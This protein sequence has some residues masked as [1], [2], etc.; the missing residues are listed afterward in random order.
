MNVT[1]YKRLGTS[2][3]LSYAQVDSNW[4][5][6]EAAFAAIVNSGG[7]VTSVSASIFTGLSVAVTNPTTTPSIAITTTL[8]GFLKGN[9]TGFT[10]Q[11]K[12]VLTT[13]VS[14]VLPIANGGTNA[15]SITSNRA[16]I[17]NGTSITAS[18]V[19]STELG[20]LSGATSNIQ[21]QLNGKEPTI[22]FLPYSKG[23]LNGSFGSR[24]AALDSLT[25]VSATTAGYVLTKDGSGNATFRVLPTGAVSS[26]NGATGVVVLTVTNG[27]GTLA[28]TSTNLNIPSATTGTTGL[29]TSTDWNTFNNKINSTGGT[30]TGPILYSGVPVV[31]DELVN[32]TYVDTHGG[33]TGSVTSVALTTGTA[34]TDINVTGSPITTSGTFTLNVPSANASNRGLLTSS[35]WTIFNNK[36]SSQWITS[37]SNIYY[38]TGNVGI[39]TSSPAY[40]LHINGGDFALSNNNLLSFISVNTGSNSTYFILDNTDLFSFYLETD[41]GIPESIWQVQGALSTGTTTFVHNSAVNIVGLAGG[42]TRMVTVNNAGLIGATTIPTASQWITTGSDIYYNTG[43]VGIGATSVESGYKLDVTGAVKIRSTHS[44]FVYSNNNV[45]FTS[46]GTI[47]ALLR[48][49]IQNSDTDQYA[50]FRILNSG[51]SGLVFDSYSPSYIQAGTYDIA[52]TSLIT[53]GLNTTWNLGTNYLRIYANSI[54]FTLTSGG[55]MV[56][57]DTTSALIGSG[58]LNYRNTNGILTNTVYNASSGSSAQATMGIISNF[59]SVVM[60][61]NNNGGSPYANMLSSLNFGF[62]LNT[63]LSN[64]DFNGSF[65]R[66]YSSSSAGTLTLGDVYEYTFTGT[67]ATWSLPLLSTAFSREYALTNLGSGSITVNVTGGGTT[68]YTTSAVTSFTIAAGDRYTIHNNGTYWVVKGNNLTTGT[69]SLTNTHIFVGNSSNVAT[70]V[71]MS[72]EATIANTGA[73]TLSN[74]A[75]IGKVLTGLSITGTAIVATDN[76]LQAF[77]KTQN[78]L[79]GIV[80]SQWVTSGANIYNGNAGG[81]SIGSTS[82]TATYK[83]DV[84]GNVLVQGGWFRSV[85]NGVAFEAFLQTS[86][87]PVYYV[88]DSTTEALGKRYRFGY[89]GSSTDV[90]SFNIVNATDNIT[91]I[92]ISGAASTLGFVGINTITPSSLFNVVKTGLGVTQTNTS[93]TALENTTS[94]TNV[95]NQISPSMRW[96]GNVWQSTA[97]ASQTVDNRVFL[98]PIDGTSTAVDA[99]WTLQ[100]SIN[101][102]T[103]TN[104]IRATKAGLLYLGASGAYVGDGSST[105]VSSGDLMLGAG[106][107]KTINFQFNN[108]TVGSIGN[109][110]DTI[111]TLRMGT[112]GVGTGVLKLIT[113][114]GGQGIGL[115]V[116]ASGITNY[117]V[118]LPAVASTVANGFLVTTTGGIGSWLDLFGTANTFSALQTFSAGLKTGAPTGGTAVTSFKIGIMRT[119]GT[120][121]VDVTSAQEVEINGILYLL[122]R[123]T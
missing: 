62:G 95:L 79:N 16:L 71:A 98:N 10:A 96:R 28:W 92:H 90:G 104:V 111:T 68:I 41:A 117:T 37:G 24:Q 32:K 30:I 59:Q 121:S 2:S 18:A 38:N 55:N 43:G 54:P 85:T 115:T 22:T 86:G 19:T 118:T 39:G 108:N 63:P 106:A 83:L 50:E 5:T 49:D 123:V 80:S 70:D 105:N 75:V 11:S 46:D 35:D 7:T 89:T 82:L 112:S 114:G 48:F 66:S 36:I 3:P 40:K 52:S 13:D 56:L 113:T 110:S 12:I 100:T 33:G 47:N 119:G 8:N 107:G 101:G 73:V 64:W 84:T 120:Y 87:N 72:G 74:S 65:G 94:A 60:A 93:G 76:I 51:A 58:F 42:G 44:T 116:P 34:G 20:F 21:T 99:W 1:L 61:V 81:V 27:V 122:S 17:F 31:G 57:G 67:T 97:A 23:G 6:I 14:G 29:L 26:V 9:G 69:M 103:Y 102:G 78:Q 4:R 25:N 88:S 77:G 15:S 53:S 109:A 91:N 45:S